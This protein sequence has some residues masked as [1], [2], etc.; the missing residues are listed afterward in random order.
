MT[1]DKTAP[2]P[3]ERDAPEEEHQRF[4]REVDDYEPY[5]SAPEGGVQTDDVP[6]DEGPDKE[7]EED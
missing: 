7:E 3:P 5:K 1:D 2:M 6:A 4:A